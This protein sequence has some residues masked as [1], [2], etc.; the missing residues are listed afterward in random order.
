MPAALNQRPNRK[1]STSSMFSCCCFAVS[2]PRNCIRPLRAKVVMPTTFCMITPIRLVALAA[3]E[4][5]PRNTNIGRVTA[6]PLPAKVLIMPAT[7]PATMARRYLQK[8]N[9]H[10]GAHRPGTIRAK[11]STVFSRSVI[12]VAKLK[13]TWPRLLRQRQCP[14]LWRA[15]HP[16]AKSVRFRGSSCRSP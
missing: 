3:P 15:G 13:R 11:R 5:S 8:R 14:A 6:E 9:I 10:V 7:M 16:P 2:P 1:E 4:S 12:A